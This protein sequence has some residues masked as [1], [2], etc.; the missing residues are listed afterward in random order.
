MNKILLTAFTGQQQIT[1]KCY[2]PE[3]KK[4]LLR[5][6]HSLN[7]TFSK[8]VNDRRKTFNTY[9]K[10]YVSHGLNLPSDHTVFTVINNH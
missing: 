10:T 7:T 2:L 9:F 6:L 4:T 5:H 1:S 3:T 8:F